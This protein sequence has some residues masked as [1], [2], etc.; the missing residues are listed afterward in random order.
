MV[1]QGFEYKAFISYSH[2]DT[3][4]AQWLLHA[5]ETYRL[6]AAVRDALGRRNGVGRIFRD[7]DEASAAADLKDEIQRALLAS[8][9]LIV[10]ASPR[11]AVSAYV[12]AEIAAF[13]TANRA[14]AVPGHI[15]TLIV[16][17]EPHAADATLECFAPALRGGLR[18]PDG[19]AFEPLAADARPTGDGRTRALAK[20]VAALLNIRYDTLVRRDL[21]RRA[22]AQRLGALA[23]LAAL[24]IAAG[25]GWVI[26]NGV[27][28]RDAALRDNRTV[29]ALGD[30]ERARR[31]LDAGNVR[32][33]VELARGGLV[34]DGSLPFL[35]QVYSVLYDALFRESRLTAE[36][37]D[38][39]SPWQTTVL[40]LPDRRYLSWSRGEGVVI[41]SLDSGVLFRRGDLELDSP[42]LSEDGR[43]VYF[44]HISGL[45][46]SRYD[47]EADLW[48][49]IDLGLAGFDLGAPTRMLVVGPQDI[50]GCTPGGLTRF[51]LAGTTRQETI[52]AWH[53]DLESCGTMARSD[54]G[55]IL[56]GTWNGEVI[57]FAAETGAEIRRYDLGDASLSIDFVRADA[58]AV[59]ASGYERTVVLPRAGGPPLL[60]FDA[61]IRDEAVSPSGRL[62]AEPKLGPNLDGDL[63]IHDLA[64]GTATKAGCFCTPIGFVDD[65]TVLASDSGDLW[66]ID[67]A[68]GE[69]RAIMAFESSQSALYLAR[70]DLI[71]AFGFGLDTVSSRETAAD[72]SDTLLVDAPLATSHFVAETEFLT[73]EDIIVDVIDSGDQSHA[74]QR[75]HIGPDGKGTQIDAA[76]IGAADFDGSNYGHDPQEVPPAADP[77]ADPPTAEALAGATL[78]WNPEAIGLVAG[79]R[80]LVRLGR[81]SA[82]FA[83]AAYLAERG[84]IIAG[85]ESGEIFAWLATSP[86]AP[87]IEL[88]KHAQAV[89]MLDVNPSATAFLSADWYRNI[90]LWPLLDSAALLARIDQRFP[91]G[92]AR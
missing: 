15:L 88:R 39:S 21:K 13:A 6:P 36:L 42:V 32:G 26:V 85:T 64:D 29:T 71:L 34:T 70:D 59:I 65:G 28:E 37:S 7:R 77:G 35:P 74:Y 81:S 5:L 51:E 17:G 9:H 16:D 25:V 89:D 24:A 23:G 55:S 61:W 62:V 60:A 90:R 19:T 79:E 86:A 2:R 63:I 92:A 48:S 75:W 73:D 72:G 41:W 49:E 43:F 57:E 33:A 30:A 12:E 87:M 44:V 78:R 69:R 66:S 27:I 8:E 47:T 10:I 31:L 58:K 40:P 14:R 53:V 84:L 50:V 18:K 82:P 76:G 52:A 4:W 68:S 22:R 91:P 11:S 80:A 54:S 20:L 46:I 67:V 83:S 45:S 3:R 56:I 1:E 38:Q